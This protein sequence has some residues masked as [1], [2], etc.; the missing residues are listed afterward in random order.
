MQ[1]FNRRLAGFEPRPVGA[2]DDRGPVGMTALGH[3]HA[4]GLQSIHGS[5]DTLHLQLA[6][7]PVA[8]EHG[9]ARLLPAL[10]RYGPIL[11]GHVEEDGGLGDVLR[12]VFGF[13][14]IDRVNDVGVLLVDRDF[15]TGPVVGVFLGHPAAGI[16][17]V[18]GRDIHLGPIHPMHAGADLHLPRREPLGEK[19][20]AQIAEHDTGVDSERAIDTATGA[21][22]ALGERRVHGHLHEGVVHLALAADDLSQRALNLV[23][24]HLPGV[25]VVGQIVEAAV[26][27]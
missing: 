22:G 24:R 26:G 6:G 13:T 15:Q 25:F 8:G 7:L 5:V 18:F 9:E 2:L 27:A 12:I 23:G 20:P 10:A 14:R 11:A 16:D 17:P 21:A 1:A 19:Q 3:H 4:L